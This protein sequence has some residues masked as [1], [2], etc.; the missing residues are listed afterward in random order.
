VEDPICSALITKQETD[1][2]LIVL[3]EENGTPHLRFR[4]AEVSGVGV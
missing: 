2:V 1:P 4:Q 3:D